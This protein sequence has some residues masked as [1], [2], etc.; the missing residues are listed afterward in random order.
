MRKLISLFTLLLLIGTTVSATATNT[1]ETSASNNYVRGYGNSFIFAEGGVEFSI[2]PDGQFDFFMQN[3][4]P[5]VNV[6][7]NTPGRSVSFNSGFDYNPYIQY[8]NFGA[9]IQIENTPVF[10][11]YFG[12]VTQIGTININYNSFGRINR[13]GGLFIHYNRNRLFSHH[14]GFINRYN[15]AYVYRPWHTFYVIPPV[16]F[17][18]VFA[19]PYRQFYTP[20]RHAYY[21]PYSDN[22]RQP[23]RTTGRRNT[24]ATNGRRGGTNSDR[25]RQDATRRGGNRIA[26]TTSSR[27]D[28]NLTS[29][30]T[31]SRS[32]NATTTRSRNITPKTRTPRT[33]NSRSTTSRN[34]TPRATST[35]TKNV[36]T[37]VT[38]KRNTS[39]RKPN[40]KAT[41]ISSN[42]K[43][44]S[45][46]QVKKSNS[47]TSSK[48]SRSRTSKTRSRS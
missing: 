31:I 10:Y 27:G 14:T 46:S 23:V 20:V 29:T 16:N 8:D 41:R 38:V 44:R 18:V 35:R 9:I 30:S 45:Q 4:G 6:G 34:V 5:N 7:V 12:R 32:E 48:E 22:F 25:Y 47:R 42:T 40:A 43:S 11:D 21:R 37:P 36:T 33:V 13:L 3:Y 17:C 26:T 19:R 24:V 15:N 28:R 2:F 39:T 1:L